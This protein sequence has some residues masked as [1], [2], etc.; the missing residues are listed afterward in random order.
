MNIK[1][2]H[3]NADELLKHGPEANAQS[4]TS[5]PEH[6]PEDLAGHA[7]RQFLKVSTTAFLFALLQIH[8][9]FAFAKSHPK[10]K[11]IVL[12]NLPTTTSYNWEVAGH[13][14]IS[15]YGM[16][17]S[18]YF[19]PPDAGTASVRGAV[20]PLLLPDASIVVA[21]CVAKPDRAAYWTSAIA[22][23]DVSTIYRD[24]RVPDAGSTIDAELDGSN[25]KLFMRQSSGRVFS[26]TYQIKGVLQPT[27][28]SKIAHAVLTD[29]A[30]AGQIAVNNKDSDSSAARAASKSW[31]IAS[32][33]HILTDDEELAAV[34]NGKAS[35]CFIITAPAGAEIY[36]DGNS[37]GKSPEGFKLMR[38]GDAPRVIAITMEGYVTVEKSFI[39]D[40]TDISIRLDLE[41]KRP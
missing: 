25:V 23:V 15:C 41:K 29:S 1:E 26:E 19:T 21:E 17:C 7:V 36:I 3:A 20:L 32:S 39:P 14:S 27:D 12:Q 35:L 6:K 10:T 40:G 30:L 8:G 2:F 13:G 31:D 5:E 37:A 34:K 33:G 28:A 38:H 16:S 4:D 22:G 11:V 18:A 24:C 9:S